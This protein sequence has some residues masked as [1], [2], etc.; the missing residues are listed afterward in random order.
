MSKSCHYAMPAPPR[1][2][3][4]LRLLTDSQNRKWCIIISIYGYRGEIPPE[5]MKEHCNT[6]C[7]LVKKLVISASYCRI[8]YKGRV[9]KYDEVI[10]EFVIQFRVYRYVLCKWYINENT[11]DVEPKNVTE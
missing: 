8:D 6:I 4:N 1:I 7:V 9:S 11:A 10:L 3:E 5:Q 2:L